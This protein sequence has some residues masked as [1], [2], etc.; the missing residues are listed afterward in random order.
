MS[1]YYF[2]FK[3]TQKLYLIEIVNKKNNMMILKSPTELKYKHS[4]RRSRNRS[5]DLWTE[6]TFKLLVWCFS[7]FVSIKTL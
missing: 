4:I 2:Y 3:I 6:M 1:V 5:C 7:L